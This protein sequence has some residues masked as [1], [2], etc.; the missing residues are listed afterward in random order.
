MAGAAV[1][2]AASGA[3]AAAGAGTEGLN[4]IRDHATLPEDPWAVA[5]GLRA[6]GKSFTIEGGRSAVDYLLAERV[7]SLP[8]G[9]QEALG[10]SP[11]VEVHPNSF[12][13]TMLEAGVPLD[14]AFVHQGRRRAVRDL[15]DGA[16]KLLRPAQVAGTANALPW[17]IIALTRT[18]PS[19][20]ARWTN[21]WSEPVDLDA[22]VEEALRH[23]ERASAPIEQA[24]RDGKPLASRAPVHG[25]TC[26]GTHL[27]YSLLAAVHAGYARGDRLPRLARQV[28]LLVWRLGADAELIDRFY[29]QAAATPAN[30]WYQ[31]DSKLKVLGHA[32]ECLAFA[33]QRKVVALGAEQ[34]RQ[35]QASAA[36]VRRMMAEVDAQNLAPVKAIS[37]ELY[38]QV[39]GDVCHARHGFTLS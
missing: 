37:A 12:L 34:Q 28:E 16:R 31:L 24:M 29:K 2:W 1:A 39:V 10:F 9:G 4:T 3:R 17:T 14:H 22:L 26:G 18:T 11:Q 30:T 19:A 27:L 13:K 33:T 21:A 35:R 20:R 15:V 38:R 25:F 32:E 23:L 8:A 36:A 6:M 7:V 5:H